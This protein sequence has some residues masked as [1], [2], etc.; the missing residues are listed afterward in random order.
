MLLEAA[1]GARELREAGRGFLNGHARSAHR[2][3]CGESIEDVV[4][5][6]Y[7]EVHLDPIHHEPRAAGSEGQVLRV[8]D[9]EGH[10]VPVA[11][12]LHTWP[13]HPHGRRLRELLERLLELPQ[14]RV[15]GVMIELH[16]GHHR[17]VTRELQKRAV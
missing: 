4:L 11:R 15:G 12:Q 6:G 5:A 7:L 17:H 1:A 9:A 3:Q 8:A 13:Q 14:I 16:V 2:R 10:G